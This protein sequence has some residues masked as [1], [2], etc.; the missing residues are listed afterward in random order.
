MSNE[1]VFRIGKKKGSI[2][3]TFRQ[4]V[5]CGSI[6]FNFGA[7]SISPTDEDL[8][9]V[10]DIIHEVD[11]RRVF[12]NAYEDESPEHMVESLREA[13]RAIHELRKGVWSSDWAR[14]IVQI[15]LHNIGEFLTQVEKKKL[16]N[17]RTPEF[18]EFED[19]AEKL[20]VQT[21]SLVAHL[22]VVFGDIV[23]PLHLPH[24]ILSEVKKQFDKVNT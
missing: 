2:T 17:Y 9:R 23:K 3:S 14:T 10:H 15:M 24:E 21:W 4:L 22:C 18:E 19:A 16:P 12:F 6:K 1:Q 8:R 5:S 20:R 13:K 11:D 7:I